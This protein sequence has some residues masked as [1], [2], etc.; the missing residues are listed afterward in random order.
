MRAPETA[1]RAQGERRRHRLRAIKSARMI[2]NCNRVKAGTNWRVSSER[3][4]S[5][6]HE[7][8]RRQQ[9]EMVKHPSAAIRVSIA[10]SPGHGIDTGEAYFAR[11]PRFC[12]SRASAPP[13]A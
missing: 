4:L 2:L 5:L 10:S 1:A 13:P 3:P 11:N 7:V 9:G 8:D 6:H 12:D